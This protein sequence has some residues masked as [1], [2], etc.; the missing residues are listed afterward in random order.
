[1]RDNLIRLQTLFQSTLHAIVI[2]TA[3]AHLCRHDVP[4]HHVS[5]YPGGLRVCEASRERVGRFG[6]HGR[7]RGRHRG[8]GGGDI[9]CP[10]VHADGT[11]ATACPGSVA[12]AQSRVGLST[13]VAL[14][15]VLELL[16]DSTEALVA[17]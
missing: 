16:G 8:R 17:K 5:H 9:A 13:P 3:S 14:D 6:C 12:R 2:P 11:E 10:L 1:M 4:H 15:R 7:S